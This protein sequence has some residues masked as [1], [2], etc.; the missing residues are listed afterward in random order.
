VLRSWLSVLRL[1]FQLD[2]LFPWFTAV[3]VACASGRTL[4]VGWLA[5]GTVMLVLSQAALELCDGYYDFVQG[6]HGR[7]DGAPTWTGGSGV[8]AEGRLAPKKVQ[9]AAFVTGAIAAALFA[10]VTL[11]WTRTGGLVV[12]LIGATCGAFW[13]M[14][15]LKLSY[16]GLGE[17]LQAIVVGPLMAAEAWV[18]ATGHLDARAF[19]VGVPFGLVEFAM[20]LS[21]NMIDRERDA[22]AGKRT[23]VVRIGQTWAARLHAAAMMLA[24][25]SLALLGALGVLGARVFVACAIVA[26]FSL[27]AS[28]ETLRASRDERARAAL[29]R[30]FPAFRVLVVAGVGALASALPSSREDSRT[31]MIVFAVAAF[32]PALV[33]LSKLP[34][35]TVYDLFAR[36]YNPVSRLL[37]FENRVRRA[38]VHAL[39]PRAGAPLLDLGCGTGFHFPELRAA[40]GAGARVIGVDPSEPSLDVAR[41]RAKACGLDFVAIHG[42]GASAAIAEPTFGGVIAAF[43][44][45]VM[46]EWQAA[47]AR[48]AAR[49]EPGARFVVLE[50]D[51][52]E[53]SA[54]AFARPLFT[55]VNKLLGATL[56]RDYAGALESAGLDVTTSR[57]G[58][59]AVFVGEKPLSP[60]ERDRSIGLHVDEQS[61]LDPD[62]PALARG[63]V[64]LRDGVLNARDE[65]VRSLDATAVRDASI[66]DDRG[67]S[68]V[69]DV[70][71]RSD[72]DA[73]P[74]AD[75]TGA[76]ILQALAGDLRARRAQYGVDPLVVEWLLRTA[77]Q[78]ERAGD[79][80]RDASSS[81]ALM[82]SKNRYV[83]Y[84][85]KKDASRAAAFEALLA[86]RPRDVVAA[87]PD[88]RAGCALLER[89]VEA[90]AWGLA[91]TMTADDAS[92]PLFFITREE[93]YHVRIG[94][95]VL[96]LFGRMRRPPAPSRLARAGV[97]AMSRFPAFLS[98][99]LVYWGERFGAAMFVRA[100]ER[101]LP[102][103][104]RAHR[105]YASALFFDLVRDE[106]EHGAYAHAA[107]GRAQ[108]AF[109]S[110]FFPVFRRLAARDCE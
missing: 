88:A 20:G 93:G 104:P 32:A 73:D 42:D 98:D 1:E 12:G 84:L 15:P 97:W 2:N 14:P 52:P 63:K 83:A 108:R 71:C 8:L 67:R 6:A 66:G 58:A 26:P 40:S 34:R 85:A 17:V 72:V 64:E 81:H 103:L 19:A 43:S 33:W 37:R 94:D 29:G 110:L 36:L 7:K 74:H 51:V 3:A 41:A 56:D 44:L 49:L 50:Q 10:V 54:F 24:V 48:A 107:L 31:I 4:H 61:A 101:I 79:G 65:R 92:D 53:D 95:A 9:I 28:A 96:A 82:L 68:R 60:S 11:A 47:I 100:A 69:T 90:E 62:A 5:L 80:D 39:A 46:Q 25:A 91:T 70:A 21:H 99:V 78:D 77:G 89:L 13:A 105:A 45:S 102:S 109:A 18:V 57:Y 106:A 87:S 22:V 23:L 59:Y 55:A 35:P 75:L 76:R 38:A 16:R 30:S 86:T 27:S